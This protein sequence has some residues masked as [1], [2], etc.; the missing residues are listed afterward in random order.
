[1][2]TSVT[3]ELAARWAIVMGVVA[4]AHSTIPPGKWPDMSSSGLASCLTLTFNRGREIYGP[5]G[6][7][8]PIVR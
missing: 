6:V 4:C 2:L 5:G 1:M 8:V 7:Q 3:A